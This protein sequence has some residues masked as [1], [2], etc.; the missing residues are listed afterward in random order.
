MYI[1]YISNVGYENSFPMQ[2]NIADQILV[3]CLLGSQKT[4]ACLWLSWLELGAEKMFRNEWEMWEKY[5]NSGR[6]TR[7][8]YQP[9]R[10]AFGVATPRPLLDNKTLWPLF[11]NISSRTQCQCPRA[12]SHSSRCGGKL[13]PLQQLLMIRL[14]S[15]YQEPGKTRTYPAL[16]RSDLLKLLDFGMSF[17]WAWAP[18]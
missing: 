11:H 5:L 9:D 17:S 18:N 3:F 6:Q 12:S 16:L 1:L 14:W 4:S 8:G 10:R 13:F 7:E 2:C 15:S